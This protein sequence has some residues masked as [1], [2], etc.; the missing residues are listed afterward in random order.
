[1]GGRDGP[2]KS[3]NRNTGGVYNDAVLR[4]GILP[5]KSPPCLCVNHIAQHVTPASLP[6][7][8]RRLTARRP[9]GNFPGSSFRE[10]QRPLRSQPS[11]SILSRVGEGQAR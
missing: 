7:A 11:S 1:M 4:G 6:A 2:K 10:D 3:L 5:R 9:R 8:R